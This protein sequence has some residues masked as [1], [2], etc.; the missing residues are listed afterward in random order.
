MKRA[1]IWFLGSVVVMGSIARPTVAQQ[2]PA[3]NETNPP[4]GEPDASPP[5]TGKR[6][7]EATDREQRLA[8]Y[9]DGC[10]FVGRF[11]L[12]GSPDASPKTEEYTISRCEKLPEPNLYRLTARIEYGDVNSEVP[13]DLRVLWSG[14]TPVITLDSFWIPGMGTFSARVLIHSGRY[15][16]TWQHGDKGGHLFGKIVKDA[17][18]QGDA[19]SSDPDNAEA[20]SDR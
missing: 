4:A 10:K 9:L 8:D 1:V 6:R 18:D 2:A 11:T 7:A 16:G 5:A 20:A 14:S 3:G 19:E 17:E 13:L 15:G 12:D